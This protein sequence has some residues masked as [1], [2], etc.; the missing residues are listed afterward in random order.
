[1]AMK[2]HGLC[3]HRVHYGEEPGAEISAETSVTTHSPVSPE[4]GTER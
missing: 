1:M 3:I 4:L 2:D